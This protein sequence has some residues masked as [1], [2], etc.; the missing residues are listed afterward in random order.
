MA[1][2]IKRRKNMPTKKN[3]LPPGQFPINQHPRWGIDHPTIPGAKIPKIDIATYT[4]TL[5]GEIEKPLTLNWSDIQKLPTKQIISDFHCV[6][7]WSILDNKWEGIPFTEILRIAKPK[8]TAKNATFTCADGYTTSLSIKELSKPNVLLATKLNDKPLEQTN[9]APLRLTVPN[10]Y[11]YKNPMW[12][13]KIKFTK[14]KELGYW[15]KHGYSDTADIWKND[16]YTKQKT[17]KPS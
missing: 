5:E 3:R 15:E 7:G 6:E 9:G 10:K 12:I 2:K 8:K 17:Q 1:P 14:N 16:R 11:A 13:T 4:L